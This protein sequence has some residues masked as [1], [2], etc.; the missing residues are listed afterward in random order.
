MYIDIY[1]ININ[2]VVFCLV[3]AFLHIVSVLTYFRTT[4]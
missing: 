3:Y 4:E 1:C 2:N